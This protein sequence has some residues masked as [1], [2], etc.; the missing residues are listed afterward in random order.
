MHSVREQHPGR[1]RARGAGAVRVPA[2]GGSPRSRGERA[3]QHRR[4]LAGAGAA[5]RASH[6]DAGGS[7]RPSA[8]PRRRHRVIG[9]RHAPRRSRWRP[10]TLVADSVREMTRPVIASSLC[11]RRARTAA[12]LTASPARSRVAVADG[13]GGAAASLL[14]LAVRGAAAREPPAGRQ[15]DRARATARTPRRR[16]PASLASLLHHLRWWS[17]DFVLT[18]LLAWASTQRLE[19]GSCPRWRGPVRGRLLHRAGTSLE[20]TTATLARVRAGHA[21]HARGRD[22][23]AAH[24]RPAGEASPSR[25]RATPGQAA[26][27]SVAR[28][29]TVIDEIRHTVATSGSRHR[30]ASSCSSWRTSSG[31]L[32]AVPQP[33]EY[34]DLRRRPRPHRRH[35]APRRR[36]LE[37]VRAWSACSTA[38][39]SP[40]PMHV[41]PDPARAGRFGLTT[42]DVADA[43]GSGL[44]GHADADVRRGE[45]RCGSASAPPARRARSRATCWRPASRCRAAARCRSTPSRP[46]HRAGR[47]EIARENLR[48]M[49][50]VTEHRGGAISAARSRASGVPDAQRT[51]PGRP[52]RRRTVASI[53]NSRRRSAAC[54]WC[55]W[56]RWRW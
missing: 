13:G 41:E 3:G 46:A 53:A 31:D 55:C 28:H 24:R 35:R 50:A 25:T 40:V 5:V 7:P 15:R 22:L 49:V 6:H 51:H 10:D 52:G 18:L 12:F 9:E 11:H 4:T 14:F 1:G 36:A 20:A 27:R 47:H 39:A 44:E 37:H 30:P 34:Q 33:I 43:L 48:Q 21:R 26:R 17:R 45:K 54:C 8:D 19:T 2:H 29:A 16:L 23:F 32:T 56:R 38:S 42:H